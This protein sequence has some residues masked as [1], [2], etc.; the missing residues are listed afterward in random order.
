MGI[1]S[2]G[3]NGCC[4]QIKW[5]VMLGEHLHVNLDTFIFTKEVLQFELTTTAKVT[6]DKQFAKL[7]CKVIKAKGG[8]DVRIDEFY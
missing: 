8:I 1:I 2:N 4:N 5:G 3:L 7:V 6:T